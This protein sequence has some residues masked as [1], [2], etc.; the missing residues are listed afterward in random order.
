MFGYIVPDKMNM[1]I[2]DFTIFKAYYCGLCKS[3]GKCQGQLYRFATNYDMTLFNI[4]MHGILDKQISFHNEV[5]IL[6]PLKK[7]SVVVG[8]ELTEQIAHINLLLMY[9]NVVDDVMDN[10]GV[11]AKAI[12]A[13]INRKTRRSQ[14]SYPRIDEIIKSHFEEL[15]A[16]EKQHTTSLDRVSEPF[17]KIM[18]EIALEVL[19]EK[20]DDNI[21]NLC[22]NLGKW[23]YLMDA[24]DDLDDDAKSHNFN[25]FLACYDGYTTKSEFLEKYHDEISFTMYAICNTIIDC[26]NH[27]EVKVS[28]GVLSNVFYLGLKKQTDDIL[29]GETKCKT[30]RL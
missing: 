30:I 22:Y 6:N 1:L 15:R 2:K 18:E 4:L 17:S 14:K 8:D 29:K 5:C 16:L 25:P 21:R 7:K 26:Y 27:I 20:A 11:K 24:L 19:G 12:K 28:E 23:V 13:M 10:G 9:Y 3:I